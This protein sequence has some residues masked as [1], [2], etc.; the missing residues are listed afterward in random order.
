MTAIRAAVE[1]AEHQL[2]ALRSGDVDGFLARFDSYENACLALAALPAADVDGED[3]LLLAQLVA[4]DQQVS[5]E[6]SRTMGEVSLKLASM[7]RGRNATGVYFAASAANV[8]GVR[9]G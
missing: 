3:R 7:R 6:L 2:A 1:L 8:T 9:E 4:I 5:S